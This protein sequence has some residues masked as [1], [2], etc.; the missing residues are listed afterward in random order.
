MI[1]GAHVSTSRA[2]R[3]AEAKQIFAQQI[4][5][6]NSQEITTYLDRH[7]P[8][9]WLTVD[10]EAQVEHAE[11]LRKAEQ[12]GHVLTT[13]IT[14]NEFTAITE[15]TVCTNDHPHL[16]SILTG[17]CA[18]VGANIVDAQIFTTTDG[19]A[20][21]T[22][23]IQREFSDDSDEER[24]A[25]NIISNIE[26]GLRGDI[27]L[28]ELIK[29]HARPTARLRAFSIEPQVVIDNEGSN[30]FTVIEVDGLDR[31]GLLYDLTTAFIDLNITVASAHIATFGERAV[32]V[33][34]V[35]DLTGQKI[36]SEDRQ[37]G[38]KKRLIEAL[39]PST[40]TDDD[41]ETGQQ[42]EE[43]AIG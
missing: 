16:L 18:A 22:L 5:D 28:P 29:H 25:G 35:R 33:F 10:I 6:W 14:C 15:I 38:I 17:A 27:Y 7:Y 20:I 12:E 37:E 43:H 36:I 1:A 42:I 24:R 31:P 11:L 26:K 9:Y 21:D 2:D 23:F 3:V 30:I 41:G 40:P 39:M 13:K 34:Y 8:A 4:T 32:D 19:I